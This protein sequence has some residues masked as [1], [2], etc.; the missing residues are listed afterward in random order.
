MVGSV[1]VFGLLVEDRLKAESLAAEGLIPIDTA[2][3]GGVLP[4][5]AV[6]EREPGSVA[7]AARGG[8][9]RAAE[10]LSA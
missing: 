4:R 10:R 5:D 9:V 7:A 6:T 1:T 8:V 2:G 3:L